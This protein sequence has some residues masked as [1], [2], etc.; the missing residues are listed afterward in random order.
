VCEREKEMEEKGFKFNSSEREKEIG[1]AQL[2]DQKSF[3]TTPL[4]LFLLY[5]LF[6][7]RYIVDS[8]QKNLLKMLLMT[9][10]MMPRE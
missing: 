1:T 7:S 6:F 8:K 5:H 2:T 3:F 4:L 10:M 9:M